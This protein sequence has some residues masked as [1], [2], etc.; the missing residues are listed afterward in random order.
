MALLAVYVN[1]YLNKMD[2]KNV[3]QTCRKSSASIILFCFHCSGCLS[4]FCCCVFCSA[5]AVHNAAGYGIKGLNEKGE[6][7]WDLI[8]NIHIWKIEASGG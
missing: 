2:V 3:C 8:S 4:L 1:K 6:V 5:D 7:S